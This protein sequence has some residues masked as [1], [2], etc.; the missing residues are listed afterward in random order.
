MVDFI[1]HH[2]LTNDQATLLI[3]HDLGVVL[4]IDTIATLDQAGLRLLRMLMG[5]V[6][7]SQL[8]QRRPSLCP[9]LLSIK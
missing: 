3:H 8:S 9:T 4:P 5:S 6:D 1:V 2:G 7:L